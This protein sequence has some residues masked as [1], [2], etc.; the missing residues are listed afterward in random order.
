[1]ENSQDELRLCPTCRMPIS[2]L[3]TRCRYCGET[4]GRPRK[5]EERFT[6]KD[7]GGDQKTTYTL[8]GNVREALEAYR[9][10]MF[11]DQAAE[12]ELPGGTPQAARTTSKTGIPEVDDSH[13][14]LAALLDL[15]SS[16]S[17]PKPKP[18]ARR[19]DFVRQAALGAAGVAA[20]LA[21]LF[22]LQFSWSAYQDY[23]EAQRRAGEVVYLNTAPSLLQQERYLEAIDE[24]LEALRFNNT[25]ENRAI[26]A[27][28][29][30][31]FVAHVEALLTAERWSQSDLREVSGLVSRAVAR[32][33]SPD[34]QA[35]MARVDG[36]ISDYKLILRKIDG[37][38]ATFIVHTPNVPEREQTVQEGDY[39][40]DRFLVKRIL[41]S[42]VRL[43]DTR[44]R[45]PGGNRQVVCRVMTQAAPD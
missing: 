36:E 37:A 21:V 3:A 43:E 17:T 31:A 39:V 33:K 20:L 22:G 34:L 14:N 25:P 9:A 2:V 8:S 32:D 13:M 28:V 40:G 15:P 35:L 4:V 11:S 10:E 5:E 12:T 42:L 29:R 30:Q 38:S 7:L 26:A 24:S 45:V 18:A 6:V 23:Q 16:T 27:E 1:M 44:V 41:P 19:Q